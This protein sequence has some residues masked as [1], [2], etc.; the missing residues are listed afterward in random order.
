MTVIAADLNMGANERE[1]CLQVVIEG[2]DVPGHRV[3]AGVAAIREIAFMRIVVA[4]TRNAIDIII[5]VGLRSMATVALLLFVDAVQREAGQVVIEEQ[6]IL[7]VDFRVAA[8][9]LAAEHAVVRIVLK[10][11]TFA[12]RS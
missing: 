1:V 2:P 9:A 6:R 11:T 5:C 3:M 8:F 10:V 7:P 12:G 4:V